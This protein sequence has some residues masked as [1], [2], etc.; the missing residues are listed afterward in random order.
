MIML[1]RATATTLTL[2]CLA[3]PLQAQSS[4]SIMPDVVY[5]HKAG[6]ANAHSFGCLCDY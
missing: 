1:T 4:G 5:G 2:L 3:T 6:M